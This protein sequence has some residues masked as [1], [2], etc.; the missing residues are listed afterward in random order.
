MNCIE[1]ARS[2]LEQTGCTCV[3]CDG[4][5]VLTDMRRGVR[6]LLDLLEQKT[7][8]TG[9]AA[10]DKVVG[11]AA[12]CLYCLLGIKTLYAAVISQPALSV[13]NQ[14]GIEISYSTL[15]PSIQN[16]TQDGPCPMEHA[17]WNIH[18][19]EEALTAI[20]ATLKKLSPP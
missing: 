7:D 17:V 16:R 2:I 6:P 4:A 18:T 14:H 1:K 5:T 10:A 9:F 20:Y 13:L 19:P 8:M 11:K 3:F 15:V 12:A